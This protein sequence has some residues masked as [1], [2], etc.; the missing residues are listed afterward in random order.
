MRDALLCP[1][2][3]SMK[4]AYY[5]KSCAPFGHHI[6]HQAFHGH[7]ATGEQEQYAAKGKGTLKL[8][9]SQCLERVLLHACNLLLNHAYHIQVSCPF[10]HVTRLD[11]VLDDC[12]DLVQQL[13]LLGQQH[14]HRVHIQRLLSIKAEQS[15]TLNAGIIEGVL[16]G[17]GHSNAFVACGQVEALHN[18]VADLELLSNVSE[19]LKGIKVKLGKVKKG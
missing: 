3:A 5:P 16:P 14:C 9:H 17:H 2:K 10:L 13:V 8:H 19:D 12:I 4:A 18:V 15:V 11:D 7:H 6:V 1:A